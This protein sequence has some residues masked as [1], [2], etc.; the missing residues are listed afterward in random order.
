MRKEV[1]GHSTILIHSFIS[2][3]LLP[4]HGK[5]KEGGMENG[6]L[7]WRVELLVNATV[8]KMPMHLK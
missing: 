3:A 4:S 8:F 2:H 1:L 7:N 6:E 5:T